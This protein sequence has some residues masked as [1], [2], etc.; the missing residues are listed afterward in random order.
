MKKL[1]SSTVFWLLTAIVVGVILGFILPEGA[2]APVL[3]VKQIAGQIIFFLVPLVILAFISSSIASLQGNT[4]KMLLFTF[5]LAYASTEGAAF[6]SL[7]ASRLVI[8]SLNIGQAAGMKDI[9]AS[10]VNLE[11]PPVMSVMSA[12]VLAIFL[13]I[14]TAWIKSQEYK[15]LLLQFRDIVLLLIKRILIPVLPFYIAANF[16]VLT[17][18]G[19]LPQMKIFLVIL[20]I[21]IAGHFVWMGVLYLAAAAYS[22]KNSLKVIKHYGPA[23]LTALGT[24]SSAASLGVAL[25]C[26]N[27]SGIMDEDN[28]SFAVPLF[29]NIH[30]CGSVLTEV[31]LVCAVSQVMYGTLPDA[32]SMIPFILLLGIFAIGAPGVP[33]GSIMASLGLIMSVVSVTLPGGEVAHFGDEAVAL[34]LTLFALQDSFGTACNLTCDGALTLIV[35]TYEKKNR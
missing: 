1:L 11:I 6:F 21:A 28:V 13:G 4:G 27:K 30:L 22:K 12:L 31:L 23:Y 24:M 20:L 19:M 10:L 32:G 2:M 3:F 16:C 35:D 7:L 34:L 33:G 8:P 18:R 14:G 9:P 26:A 17:Y 29:N 25:E 5:A 15:T